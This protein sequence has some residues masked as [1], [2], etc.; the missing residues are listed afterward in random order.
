[1]FFSTNTGAVLEGELK[2]INELEQEVVYAEL[3]RLDD[4][5]RK[6]TLDKYGKE[7]EEAGLISRKTLVRLTKSDDLSRRRKMVAFQIAKEHKDPLWTQLVKNRVRERYLI[8]QIMKKYHSGA[9]RGAKIAQKAY[10]KVN[11]LAPLRPT[12]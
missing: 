10:L 12:N 7:L 9:E 6:E 4:A 8:N 11:K 5:S 3:A 2:N 1:M